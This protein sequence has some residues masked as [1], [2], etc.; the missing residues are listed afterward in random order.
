MISGVEGG[1]GGREKRPE[2]AWAQVRARFSIRATGGS[3][4]EELFPDGGRIEEVVVFSG[5]EEWEDEVAEVFARTVFAV[6]L[7]QCADLFLGAI[8]HNTSEFSFQE[9]VAG[10]HAEIR[11]AWKIAIGRELVEF[12]DFL[13]RFSEF[14]PNG[15]LCVKCADGH[16]AMDDLVIRMD[17]GTGR[18]EDAGRAN[19]PEEPDEGIGETGRACDGGRAWDCGVVSGIVFE[20]AIVV[21]QEEEAIFRETQDPE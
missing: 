18:H 3:E 14:G 17:I 21:V 15:A 2:A 1:G 8:C 4:A 5:D 6:E 11:G 9:G 13:E 10:N 16:F 20:S 7:D 19:M 12:R